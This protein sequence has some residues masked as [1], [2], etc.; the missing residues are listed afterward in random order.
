MRGFEKSRPVPQERILP[1]DVRY[2]LQY[3]E[4]ALGPSE[5]LDLVRN[6]FEREAAYM[7][8]KALKDDR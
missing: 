3:R 1:S 5:V 6:G 7:A 8:L 4:A 2:A